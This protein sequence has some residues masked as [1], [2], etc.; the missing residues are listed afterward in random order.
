MSSY[1][2]SERPSP[3]PRP[4]GKVIFCSDFDVAHQKYICESLNCPGIS[5]SSSSTW[6]ESFETCFA[7][8]FS[9][10]EAATQTKQCHGE[11]LIYNPLER[12][13]QRHAHGRWAAPRVLRNNTGV[14]ELDRDW[15][16][17]IIRA[18]MRPPLLCVDTGVQTKSGNSLSSTRVTSAG[19]RR[20]RHKSKPFLLLLAIGKSP[21][22]SSIHVNR[23][24]FDTT[25]KKWHKYTFK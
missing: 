9:L 6:R 19:Q 2:G 25:W 13:Y 20:H 14:I 23:S 8:Q 12:L 18:D 21:K 17:L 3:R 11:G 15:L 5:L 16:R 24:Y 22:E 1:P 4:R 7:L 10:A